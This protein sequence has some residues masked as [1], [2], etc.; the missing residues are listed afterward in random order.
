MLQ[1]A[2]KLEAEAEE[3]QQGADGRNERLLPTISEG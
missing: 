3:L 1:E 2:E